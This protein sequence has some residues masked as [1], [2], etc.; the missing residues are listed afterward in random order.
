M[1]AGFDGPKAHSL[2]RV[3]VLRGWIIAAAVIVGLH[4]YA[5]VAGITSPALWPLLG[6]CWALGAR[7]A[8]DPD[9]IAII[10]TTTRTLAGT[11]R[12]APTAGLWFA[13]GHS[14]LVAVISVLALLGAATILDAA[15][16]LTAVIPW[17]AA[18]TLLVIGGYNLI[19]WWRAW[20]TPGALPRPGGLWS[21]ASR[22]R[23]PTGRWQ[24]FALGVGFGLTFDTAG[25]VAM[26]AL[27]AQA[28]T[29]TPLAAALA[30]PGAFCGGMALFDTLDSGL[31]A[32]TY[33]RATATRRRRILLSLTAMS[34][35]L[36]LLVAAS[37]VAS[38]LTSGHFPDWWLGYG[39]AVALVVAAVA[40]LAPARKNPA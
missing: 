10:D 33:L 31:L 19:V 26:L 22:H 34:S 15:S 28:A 6:A 17:F 37:I 30:L 7:H 14:T 12:W 8:F 27:T 2:G 25:E 23:H 1:R 36:A 21:Q 39:A 29:H 38:A 13:L 35:L 3:T 20:R 5:A 4:L 24:L 40:A 11:T 32:H 18:A 16:P 9:H